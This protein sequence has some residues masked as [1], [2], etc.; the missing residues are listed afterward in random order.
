MEFTVNCCGGFEEAAMRL[1]DGAANREAETHAGR[2]TR[3]EWFEY[4][5]AHLG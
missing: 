2:F 3:D 4:A 1:R 5:I